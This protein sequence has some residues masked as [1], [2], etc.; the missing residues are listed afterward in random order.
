MIKSA[1]ERISHL[2]DIWENVCKALNSTDGLTTTDAMDAHMGQ[3]RA[4]GLLIMDW[5]YEVERTPDCDLNRNTLKAT[6]NGLCGVIV[7]GRTLFKDGERFRIIRVDCF[8]NGIP[9]KAES[10]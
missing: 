2:H 4:A 6:M 9:F 1:K 8:I 5:Y 3:N 10:A 7:D